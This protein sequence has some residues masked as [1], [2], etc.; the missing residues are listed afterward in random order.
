MT[1]NTD[2]YQVAQLC[3]PT[4]KFILTWESY[5]LERNQYAACKIQWRIRAVYHVVL[6][7]RRPLRINLDSV[8]AKVIHS[9]YFIPC[10]SPIW[11]VVDMH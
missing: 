7:F 4:E 9:E 10:S 8:M 3:L 5:K 1:P 6:M 11:S 2:H